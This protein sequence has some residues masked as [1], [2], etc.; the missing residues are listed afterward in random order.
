MSKDAFRE[1]SKDTFFAAIR[2]L[3]V[4]PQIQ[5]GP[6]PYTSLWKLPGGQVMGKVVNSLSPGEALPKTSF[7]LPK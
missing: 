6:W 5:P 4:H 3:N 7:W 2:P 1:A